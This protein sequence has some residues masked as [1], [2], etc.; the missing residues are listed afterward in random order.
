M[1]DTFT[2]RDKHDK[3]AAGS[4]GSGSPT[5]GGH[6]SHGGPAGSGPTSGHGSHGGHGGTGPTG[7]GA[8]AT[9]TDPTGGNS[10]TTPAGGKAEDGT[11][12]HVTSPATAA[13]KIS[14]AV[15]SLTSDADG[16]TAREPKYT[17]TIDEGVVEKISSL[18]AQKVDG[19]VDMKGSV[20]SMIQE[21]LG[22]SADKKGVDADVDDGTATVELS[23]ILEYGRS[24]IE[25]FDAIKE[26]VVSQVHDMTGLEVVEL[27]VNVVDVAD[28]AAWDAEHA[29][30]D[31]EKKPDRR[32]H[33]TLAQD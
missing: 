12:L 17:L 24:A 3:H 6:G 32:S 8:G 11:T 13:D 2:T 14:D 23:I 28:K 16:P 20:F 22:G 15:T 4:G 25:V 29:P 5:S 9:S 19:I 7:N 1:T 21:G 10:A 31:D 26:T 27:I 18:A 30:A 33:V